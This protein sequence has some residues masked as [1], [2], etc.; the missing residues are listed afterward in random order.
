MRKALPR[1]V[2]PPTLFAILIFFLVYIPVGGPFPMGT[3]FLGAP[4]FVV[5]WSC[6]WVWGVKS[7]TRG[8]ETRGREIDSLRLVL[9]RAVA[10]RA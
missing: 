10:C 9:A 8:R 1:V 7:S 6:L 5:S 3:L 2:A 4:C